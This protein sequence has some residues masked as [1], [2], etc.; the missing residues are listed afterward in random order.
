MWWLCLHSGRS[1]WSA[2]CHCLSMLL[3]K[4][5]SLNRGK[6]PC[7]SVLHALLQSC[8]FWQIM[9]LFYTS[10]RRRETGKTL[11]VLSVSHLLSSLQNWTIRWRL[12]G[13]LN[14]AIRNQK[15]MNS[16]IL[17]CLL[18]QDYDSA[19]MATVVSWALQAITSGYSG[20]G[21]FCLLPPDKQSR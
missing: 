14:R 20:E 6:L 16:P 5:Q 21:N 15:W 4:I 13:A 8:S 11:R 9:S 2:F 3:G 12:H 19:K 7:S 10:W 18:H 1:S 17:K